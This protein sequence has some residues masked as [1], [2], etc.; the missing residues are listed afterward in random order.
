MVSTRVG[1]IENVV[2]DGVTGLLSANNDAMAFGDNLLQVVEDDALRA[3]M[4]AAGWEHVGKRYHYSRLVSDT[5]EL[6][7]RLIA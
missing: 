6:Y 3:R 5:A 7:Y 2:Q 4:A 1:G